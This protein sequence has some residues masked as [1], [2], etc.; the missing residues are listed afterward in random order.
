MATVEG[1]G[2]GMRL[3]MRCQALLGIVQFSK[4]QYVI[5][6]CTGED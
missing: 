4:E 5:E 6:T 1:S 2:G 3:V